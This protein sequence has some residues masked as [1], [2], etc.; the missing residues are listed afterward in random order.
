MR[1]EKKNT[2]AVVVMM[3]MM[4]TASKY[5]GA[6]GVGLT[7]DYGAAPVVGK[8]AGAGWGWWR[9]ERAQIRSW[10]ERKKRRERERDEDGE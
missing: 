6:W 7:R 3:A 9:G 2:G 5:R 1:T 8:K 4:E 10:T